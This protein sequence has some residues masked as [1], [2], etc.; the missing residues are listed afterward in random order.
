MRVYCSLCEPRVTSLN[1]WTR[2]VNLLSFLLVGQF[3]FRW[4]VRLAGVVK[5]SGRDIPPALVVARSSRSL[6]TP[7]IYYY[8]RNLGRKSGPGRKTGSRFGTTIRVVSQFPCSMVMDW[9]S[10][11][12][13]S[14]SSRF[15]A[16]FGAICF[17]HL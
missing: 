15:G 3:E 14:Q 17:A 13:D 6:H 9:P 10:T 11:T 5:C 7:S 4:Q 8:H 16:M 1:G 12:T 2:P